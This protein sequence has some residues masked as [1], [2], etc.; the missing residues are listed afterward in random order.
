MV[1][2]LDLGEKGPDFL[3]EGIAFS[4]AAVEIGRYLVIA[5]LDMDVS[6]YFQRK[7]IPVVKFKDCLEF[8]FR[9]FDPLLLVI[10][11]AK[12]KVSGDILGITFEAGF[13]QRNGRI[14]TA[15]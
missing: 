6:Q 14:D 13:A 10:A 15:G 8:G 3:I 12:N 11:P 5:A 9:L 7:N 1:K 4:R 2:L